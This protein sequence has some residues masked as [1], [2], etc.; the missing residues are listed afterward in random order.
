MSSSRCRPEKPRRRLAQFAQ[1]HPYVKAQ[2]ATVVIDHY[3]RVVRPLLGGRAKA[4]VVCESREEAVQWKR[5]LDQEI[6]HHGHTDVKVLVAFSGEVTVSNPQADNVGMT[7]TEPA[8]N[9]IDGKPLPETK[10][11]DEFNKP[12]YGILIVAEKYQTGFDQPLLCG[13][14]VDKTLTGVNAVQTLSRLNRAHPGKENVYVLDFRNTAEHIRDAFLPFYERT[15][16][17]PTDP[18]VLFDAADKVSVWG[19]RR[20]RPRRFADAYAALAGAAAREAAPAPVEAHP[21]RVRRRGTT[22]R[23]GSPGAAR[24]ARPVHP[25]LL[26]PGPGVAVDPARD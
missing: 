15:E 8:M 7:Y 16:A 11:P 19:D 4:M 20:R 26:V 25:L 1:L 21:A 5:A 23:R 6:E 12:A 10:L 13:M 17:I 9:A 18:N 24:G 3:K 22:R 14:Y 2:K